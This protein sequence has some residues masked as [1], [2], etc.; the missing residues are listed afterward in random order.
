MINDISS[1]SSAMT[2]MSSRTMGSSKPPPP[3]PEEDIFKISDTDSDGTVSETE[4]STLVNSLEEITGYS[5]DLEDALSIY[6]TDEDGS[7]NGEELRGLMES[8]GIAPPE[9]NSTEQSGAGDI[10]SNPAQASFSQVVSSYSQ[11][12]GEDQMAQLIELMKE[13]T[14]AGQWPSIS[15][16]A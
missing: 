14:G 9:M 1:M 3:P 5:I 6:D 8:S 7:L 15:I 13:Q 10:N 2:M 12:T 4:L 11:N 16:S